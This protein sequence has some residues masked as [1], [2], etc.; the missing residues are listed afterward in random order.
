MKKEEIQA[1]AADIFKNNPEAKKVFIASDGNGFISEN[2]A[3]LHKNT[4]K[5]DK[6]TITEVVNE[7]FEDED[8]GAKDLPKTQKDLMKLTKPALEKMA[9]DLKIDL[10]E[11][12]TKAKIADAI[13][14]LE[15]KN[16]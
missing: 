1:L 12:D 15:A 10:L 8:G 6:V 14:A 3:L 16:Q 5:G 11:L 4:K 7:N 9:E 13:I 2:A